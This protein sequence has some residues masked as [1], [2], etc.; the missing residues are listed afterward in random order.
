M[1]AVLQQIAPKGLQDEANSNL[2]SADPNIGR[3]TAI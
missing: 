1:S 3:R 2:V